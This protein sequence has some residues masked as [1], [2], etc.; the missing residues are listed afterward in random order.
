MLTQREFLRRV[1]SRRA[2]LFMLGPLH[3]A[4]ARPMRMLRTLVEYEGGAKVQLAYDETLE[5]QAVVTSGQTPVAVT[6]AH[7]DDPETTFSL[8]SGTGDREVALPATTAAKFRASR[9]NQ[10]GARWN[11]VRVK[12][13]PG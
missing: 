3:D 10:I 8:Q 9:V 2:G 13:N 5:L 1:A 4:A 12:I 7:P 6:I 11:G